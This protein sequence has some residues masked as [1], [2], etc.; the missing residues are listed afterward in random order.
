MTEPNNNVTPTPQVPAVAHTSHA[1]PPVA[2]A[3]EPTAVGLAMPR[4]HP[5]AA[6]LLWPFLTLGIYHLVWYY[7]IHTE[8]AEFD[9][10]RAVPTTG[11]V[12]VLLLLGWTLIAPLVS[13]YNCGTRIRNAQRAAGLQATCSPGVGT[14]LMLLMGLGVLYYQAE[15]N[16]IVDSYGVGEGQQIPLHV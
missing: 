4:R 2:P 12:L 1:R 6:W 13:Y 15:L 14:A 3:G 5:V 11:P 10:R 7:K 8:L 9:R 16:K